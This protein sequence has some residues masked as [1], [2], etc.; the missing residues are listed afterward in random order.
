MVTKTIIKTKQ[1]KI[2]KKQNSQA[3]VRTKKNKYNEK[4]TEIKNCLWN[5]KTKNFLMPLDEPNKSNRSKKTIT[6]S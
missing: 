3:I 4:N 5:A 2:T 1:T 6:K